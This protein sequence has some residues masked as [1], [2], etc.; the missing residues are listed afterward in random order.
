M[1]T[2]TIINGNVN[3]SNLN[4]ETLV[5]S[6]KLIQNN[7][8]IYYEDNSINSGNGGNDIDNLF[9]FP[10]FFVDESIS[11]DININHINK[12][13]LN[14]DYNEYPNNTDIVYSINPLQTLNYTLLHLLNYF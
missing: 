1:N 7:V 4:Y 6:E 11:N 13:I 14:K 5:I 9:P 12:I 10:N 3:I 8:K 2:N